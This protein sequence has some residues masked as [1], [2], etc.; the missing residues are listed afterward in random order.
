MSGVVGFCDDVLLRGGGGG[1]GMLGGGGMKRL[2]GLLTRCTLGLLRGGATGLRTSNA[3]SG[4]ATMDGAGAGAAL[5]TWPSVCSTAV[6]DAGLAIL[7]AGGGGG[8]LRGLT[9]W[10]PVDVVRRWGGLSGLSCTPARVNDLWTDD[11]SSL[12]GTTGVEITPLEGFADRVNFLLSAFPFCL[13]SFFVSFCF[14]SAL[15]LALVGSVCDAPCAEA[16]GFSLTALA[17]GRCDFSLAAA[18]GF[19]LTSSPACLSA[20]TG[21]V[22]DRGIVSIGKNNMIVVY[23]IL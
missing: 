4:V 14:F 21:E 11:G 5:T 2:T 17:C 18:R 3:A 13:V 19:F 10:I 9:L 8:G 1:R 15:L 20:G 22:C 7:L 6:G 23:C 16:D 12:N